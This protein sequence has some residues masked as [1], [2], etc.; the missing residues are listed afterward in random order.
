MSEETSNQPVVHSA[1]AILIEGPSGRG[2][3][4]SFRNLPPNES[5]I[6]NAERK[7]LP[8]RGASKFRQERPKNLKELFDILNKYKTS[9]KLKVLVVDSLS[10][11]ADMIDHE[12]GII[13]SGYDIWRK[14][15]EKLYEMFKILKEYNDNGI[16]VILTGHDETISGDN[17]EMPQKRLKIKG[18]QWEG[19]VEKEFDIVLWANVTVI[20]ETNVKYTFKTQTNGIIPAKSPAGMLPLEIDNDVQLVI[21]MAKKYDSAEEQIDNPEKTEL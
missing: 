1:R 16:Y 15:G 6:I 2:K 7:A 19:I 4:S 5:L 9:K 17:G 14:Y 21:E 13:Y 12:M 18:K 3:S 8:F 11:V 10:A 20:D